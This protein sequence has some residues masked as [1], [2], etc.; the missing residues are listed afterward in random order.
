VL[1]SLINTGLLNYFV[2]I[3]IKHNKIPYKTTRINTGV[4]IRAKLGKKFSSPNPYCGGVPGC[5]DP[6][7]NPTKYPKI[8]KV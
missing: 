7:P 6:P 1:Q 4:I 2:K 8:S 3:I 5:A